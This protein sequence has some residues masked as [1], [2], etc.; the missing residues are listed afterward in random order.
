MFTF[1]I[2]AE[3]AKELRDKIMEQAGVYLKFGIQ[4]KEGKIVGGPIEETPAAQAVEEAVDETEALTAAESEKRGRGRK[5]FPRDEKGN[6]IRKPLT[7]ETAKTPD[8]LPAGVNGPVNGHALSEPF[9][10][11]EEKVEVPKVITREDAT[12]AL[13]AVNAQHGIQK[14]TEIL[15]SLGADRMGAVKPENYEKLVALCN[16]ATAL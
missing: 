9:D 3:T 16:E 1:T 14:A 5:P 6:I 15:K 8:P 12:R 13:V 11:E 4:A 10:D 2:S 7:P